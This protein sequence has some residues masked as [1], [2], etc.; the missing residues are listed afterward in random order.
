MDF[1]S[2]LVLFNGAVPV[3]YATHYSYSV[4]WEMEMKINDELTRICKEAVVAFSLFEWLG[5]ENPRNSLVRS[6]LAEMWS[7]PSA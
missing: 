5:W 4:E 6:L 2:S 3:A 7:E 1:I